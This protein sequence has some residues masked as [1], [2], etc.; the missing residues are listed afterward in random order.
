MNSVWFWSSRY[1]VGSGECPL[2]FFFV[3]RRKR[4][5]HFHACV[6]GH[7]HVICSV[8]R[9]VLWYAWT[10]RI[11][12][13][14][15]IERR[16]CLLRGCRANGYCLIAG[17]YESVELC[18]VKRVPR[19]M[20]GELLIWYYTSCRCVVFIWLFL[21][22]LLLLTWYKEKFVSYRWIEGMV[23]VQ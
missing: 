5:F 16:Y 18:W 4:P 2:R 13:G 21:L 10:S 22:L 23:V 9:V 15:K 6:F 12:A 8:S 14:V 17:L 3:C 19:I 1:F 7:G 20:E 11:W